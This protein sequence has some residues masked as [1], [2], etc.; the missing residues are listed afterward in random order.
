MHQFS[1]RSLAQLVLI[2]MAVQIVVIAY[3]AYENWQGRVHTV[4]DVRAGCERIKEDRR[5]NAGFQR[6]QT[7]YIYRV[8]E[9]PN[10][11][12]DVTKAASEALGELDRRATRL[13]KRSKIKCE[14]VYPDVSFFP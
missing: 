13:E 14:E 7:T 11:P 1:D 3:I 5:D 4:K 12:P 8:S 2:G 9:S 10:A 6:A